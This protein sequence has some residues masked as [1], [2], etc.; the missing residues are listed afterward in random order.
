VVGIVGAGGW[1]NLRRERAAA[2]ASLIG[3]NLFQ[4][5][6]NGMTIAA[7]SSVAAAKPRY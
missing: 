6:Q 2:L 5:G 7:Q 4:I 3:K 1:D